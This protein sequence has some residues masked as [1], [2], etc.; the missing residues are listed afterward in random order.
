MPKHRCLLLWLLCSLS[1]LS[2]AQI[3]DSISLKKV[4]SLIQVSRA[5]TNQKDFD[6]AMKINALADSLAM[7]CCGPKSAAFGSVCFNKGRIFH[8]KKSYTEAEQYYLQAKTIRANALGTH[9]L[10]Y[11]QVL[12]NL[13]SMYKDMGKYAQSEMCWSEAVDLRAILLGKEHP[14]YAYGLNELGLCYLE[15]AQYEKAASAFKETSAFWAKKSGK[16]CVDYAVSTNNLGLVYLK[17]GQYTESERALTEGLKIREKIV[18]KEHPDYASSLNNLANLYSS[19]GFYE[20]AEPLLIAAKNIREKAYGKTNLRYAWSV[21]NLANLYL[22]LGKFDKADPLLAEALQ[23]KAQTVGKK[24]PDYAT[25]LNNQGS[26]YLN[27]GIYDKAIA[28]FSEGKMIRETELG[29]DHPDYATNLENLALVYGCVGNYDQAE[30]LL[31]EALSIDEKVRGDDHPETISTLINLASNCID[32]GDLNRAETLLTQAMDK[33]KSRSDTISDAYKNGLD[34]LGKFYLKKRD[35]PSAQTWLERALT[36]SKRI[37]GN[38]EQSTRILFD[39][40]AVHWAKGDLNTAERYLTEGLNIQKQLQTRAAR[41]LSE[42][43]LSGY[44]HKTSQQSDYAISFSEVRPQAASIAYDDVLF[45][46]GFLL[47]IV[48]QT[49]REAVNHPE[50]ADLYERMKGLHRRLAIEYAKAPNNQQGVAALEAEA[51]ILE[52]ELSQRVAGIGQALQQVTWPMIQAKLKP[53]EASLEFVHF[54]RNT[55]ASMASDDAWMYGVLVLLPGQQSP[56]LI[57]LCPAQEVEKLLAANGR[58]PSAIVQQVYGTPTLYRLLWQPIEDVLS[59]IKTVYFSPAGLLHRINLEA[60]PTHDNGK[61]ADRFNF[62]RLRSTRQLAISDDTSELQGKDAVLMGGIQ[63]DAESL[64]ATAQIPATSNSMRAG[65]WQMSE[66]DSVRRVASWPYLKWT[67]VEVSAA[68]DAL[69]NAGWQAKTYTDTTASEGFFK[70][71]GQSKPSPRVVHLATHG[72]FFSDPPETPVRNSVAIQYSQNPMIRSGLILA[73]ANYA[74]KYGHSARPD[75]EDGILT[76][77]EISQMNFQ[78]TELVVLSACETGLGDIRGNEG[79][80]GLQRAF[81]IAGAQ[82]IIMSLWQ[83]PDYQT[84]EFMYQFYTA[85]QDS[86][87]SVPDAFYRAQKKMQARYNDPFYWAGFVLMR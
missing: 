14:D 66:T 81:K 49:S 37:S 32:K 40:S 38:Q 80:Y 67:K 4:D 30:T 7:A 47:N 28:L 79:V 53:D 77:Y 8:L 69:T 63:Y 20:R 34:L 36:A 74:W 78:N 60:L 2:V 19:Q 21:N 62:V 17:S 25:T 82:N 85:W 75:E 64:A 72:F 87:H 39:L 22:G 1:S 33:L 61:L 44:V 83:V 45:Q 27:M 15:T 43:E 71:L 29:K 65:I 16:E 50:I 51:N 56:R 26:V 68:A 55:N 76:A 23:I 86:K 57:T 24:H 59:G 12:N 18:G 84:Q 9:H 41:H 11:V 5:L 35:Y 13:G 54:Q 6:G 3:A 46:K 10:D 70:T 52:K 58:T 42:E 73:G 48:T 31:E